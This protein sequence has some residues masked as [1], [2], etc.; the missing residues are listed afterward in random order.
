MEKGCLAAAAAWRPKN[1]HELLNVQAAP[2]YARKWIKCLVVSVCL[3]A[4]GGGK[5]YADRDYKTPP[6]ARFT[7]I[8]GLAA[9]VSHAYEE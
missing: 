1:R 2:V 8:H 3:D 9:T 7:S 4:G 5:V 6:D